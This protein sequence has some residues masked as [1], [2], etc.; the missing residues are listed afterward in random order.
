MPAFSVVRT[1]AC[2]A[3]LA[4]ALAAHA[5]GNEDSLQAVQDALVSWSASDFSD[6]GPRAE[7]V[8]NV[9][10]RYA[11]KDGG[12]RSYMLCGQFLPAGGTGVGWM[13]FATIKTDPYEQWI[14]GQAEALCERALPLSA[15]DD[16]L[17]AALQARLGGGPVSIGQP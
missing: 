3:L 7:K 12:E 17:S 13:Q 4:T 15:G 5:H 8:R 10:V 6:H 14:G 16:D 11:E 1:L 9:H 2:I